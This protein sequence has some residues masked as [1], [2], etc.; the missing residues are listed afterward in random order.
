[1]PNRL[2]QLFKNKL[3]DHAF[4][5]SVKAWERVKDGLVKKN[6]RPLV[7]RI[8][9]AVMLVGALTSTLLWLSSRH[10]ASDSSS[11]LGKNADSKTNTVE[12]T[13][14]SAP[15][16]NGAKERTTRQLVSKQKQPPVKGNDQ[17]V[18]AIEDQNNMAQSKITT[19]ARQESIA[20]TPDAVGVTTIDNQQMEEKPIVLVYRL[21]S[22]EPRLV[23]ESSL[24]PEPKEK[25]GLMKA[26]IFARDAKNGDTGLG[27]LRQ[28]KD[29]LFAFNFRKDKQNNHK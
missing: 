2:D 22:I 10:P 7:L 27:D 21:E 18:R 6:N 17:K 4:A 1:M 3:S 14:P 15:S 12:P 29:E 24:T 25:S 5:P 9:A 28:A 13:N 19:E 23:A 8:A 20:P 11:T 26:I 16:T